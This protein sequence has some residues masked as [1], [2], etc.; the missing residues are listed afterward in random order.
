MAKKKPVAKKKLPQK[1]S[2]KTLKNK[3]KK[4]VLTGK[5][6]SNR[7]KNQPVKKL[8]KSPNKKKSPSTS[9]LSKQ[10]STKK[11]SGKLSKSSQAKSKTIRFEGHILTGPIVDIIERVA[12]RNR[13]S[14]KE[15]LNKHAA[16]VRALIK[17]GFTKLIK[18]VDTIISML[19][20]MSKRKIIIEN[21]ASKKKF[22]SP[23]R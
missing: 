22:L 4:P 13:M 19:H 8:S 14:V 6:L 1:K 18:K 9:K 17:N 5:K 2:T 11:S 21:G 23:R 7:S 20:K 10:S 12:R 16:E 3:A 15:Y